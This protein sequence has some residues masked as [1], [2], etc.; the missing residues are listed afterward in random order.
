MIS[1]T[2]MAAKQEVDRASF[3]PTKT[4]PARITSAAG[5]SG[6]VEIIHLHVGGQ[7]RQKIC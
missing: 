1:M 2:P 7:P 6:F 3:V 4:I 5:P